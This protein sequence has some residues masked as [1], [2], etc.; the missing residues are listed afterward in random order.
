MANNLWLEFSNL[1]NEWTL[2][3][4]LLIAACYLVGIGIA[5]FVEPRLEARLRRIEKQPQL[6]RA[7]AVMLR[8]IRWLAFASLLWA[9]FLGMRELT[10]PSRSYFVGLAASL[11]LAWFVISVTTRIIRK[12]SLAGLVAACVWTVAALYIVGLLGATASLLDWLAVSFGGVRISLYTLL[13]GV[14]V[15]AVLLWMGQLTGDFI[16]ARA[17]TS[18]LFSPSMHVLLG[19]LVK[20]LLIVIAA[21]A[22]L[23]AAGIDFTVLTVFSGALGLGLG[24][25]LQRVAS[26][27]ASGFIMLLD[28]SIKPGDVIQVGNTFGWITSIR[29]RYVSLETRDG[30]E[31]LIPNEQFITER[32]IN[33]SFTDRKIRLEVKFGVDYSSDPHFVRRIVSEAV[34]KLDRVLVHPPPIC[35]LVAFGDSSLDLVV[36]FW[37][38]DP[39][40]GVTNIKGAALLAIWDVLKS[41]NIEIPYPHLRVIREPIGR[42]STADVPGDYGGVDLEDAASLKIEN[43]KGATTTR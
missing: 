30:A 38:F 12:R 26:N 37:I 3:Q 18:D 1:L 7:L 28:R 4:V 42:P 43:A 22:A 31:Y 17:K 14:A 11:A 16:E 33:W 29:A 34:G 19:K 35:H 21:G 39:E 41:N 32:V 13:K 2:Y 15:L 20:A 27:L 36:R 9:C 5:A 23:S 40:E 8:R 6:L 10:W 25:G 24:F